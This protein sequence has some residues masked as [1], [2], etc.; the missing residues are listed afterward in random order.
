MVPGGATDRDV[1][2]G[3]PIAARSI[4][5]QR[6]FVILTLTHSR[7]AIS[8]QRAFII[9]THSLTLF[10]GGGLF[11]KAKPVGGPVFAGSSLLLL[12]L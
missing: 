12:L 4:G 11:T 1:C 5:V 9:L 3:E 8:V 7:R 2:A 6:A 10:Y